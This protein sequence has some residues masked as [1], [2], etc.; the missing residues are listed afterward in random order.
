[1]LRCSLGVTR[2]DATWSCAVG[3]GDCQPSDSDQ[4]EVDGGTLALSQGDVRSP[5]AV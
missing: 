4:D 2:P 5:E 3:H 1:M